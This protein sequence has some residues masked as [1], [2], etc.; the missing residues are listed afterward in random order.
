[1]TEQNKTIDASSLERIVP[2]ELTAGE[3]TGHETLHLHVERYQ[4]ASLNLIPGCVLDI[5]CGV[6]YG[7]DI[8]ARREVIS[9]ALGVDISP[10]AVHYANSRYASERV[11]YICADA[12]E[13]PSGRQFNN[14]VS[15]ETI[16]HMDDP[17]K[18]F[19]TLVDLLAPGGRLI[20]SVPVTPSVDANPHHKTNFSIRSFRNMGAQYS[21][22]YV[23]SLEQIQPFN[24]VAIATRREVRTTNLRRNLL[25]FYLRHP[26]HFGLRLWST[27]KD[28]FVNKYIT[29]VWHRKE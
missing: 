4:F 27:L 14:V 1:M 3:S 16:E 2:E 25:L 28:G 26:S 22:E 24:P 21:L 9:E 10:S 11:S 18:F 12:V 19:A 17:Q 5:A 29:V 7:T 6:G 13:Y 23:C 15:L 8:L 20:A